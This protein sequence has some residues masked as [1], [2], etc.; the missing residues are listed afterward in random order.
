MQNER[1]VVDFLV[2]AIQNE[3]KLVEARK[4][5]LFAQVLASRKA[6]E[7]PLLVR[8]AANA[9]TLLSAAWLRAVRIT[10]CGY[11]I[12]LTATASCGLIFRKVFMPSPGAKR[13]SPLLLGEPS[14]VLMLSILLG[15][16]V[17]QIRQ[18][19]FFCKEKVV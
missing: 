4:K 12:L 5:R 9:I 13:L 2:E 15:Q 8:A 11:G 7:N 3:S 19:D 14:T 10:V 6:K 17:V 16:I 1:G 18:A